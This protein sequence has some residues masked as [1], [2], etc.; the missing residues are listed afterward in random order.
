MGSVPVNCCGKTQNTLALITAEA[1]YVSVV[2]S[3]AAASWARNFLMG[4]G[5]PVDVDGGA[6]LGI[7][8]ADVRSCAKN[9]NVKYY[10]V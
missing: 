5:I 4:A 9:L 6:E 2:R 8:G 3:A 1:E 10:F 7:F